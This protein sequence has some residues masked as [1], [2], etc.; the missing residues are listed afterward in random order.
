MENEAVRLLNEERESLMDRVRQ[1][2]RAL[3]F[4]LGPEKKVPQKEVDR[5]V[6]R[7]LTL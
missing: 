6:E 3:G 1:I 2:D 7:I 5:A 4:L